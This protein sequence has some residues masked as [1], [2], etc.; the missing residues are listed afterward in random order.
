MKLWLAAAEVT[1]LCRGKRAYAYRL[2]D[3]WD[4]KRAEAVQEYD[5]ARREGVDSEQLDHT[6]VST[7]VVS[8]RTLADH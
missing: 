4:R 5:D 2:V 7:V 6:R 1:G 8:A 3:F